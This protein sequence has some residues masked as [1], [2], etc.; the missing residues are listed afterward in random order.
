MGGRVASPTLVGR[1]EE[2][3]LLEAARGRAADAEPA[4]VLVGGEAGVGKTRLVTEL[5]SRCAADGTSVLAGG[6]V[7]VGGDGLP[8]AP[9]TEALRP[10]P[11]EFGADAVRELAGPS[12]RELARLLPALGEPEVGPAGQVAQARLFELVLGL[13]ARLSQQTPVT[14]VVEDLHWADQSTRDLLAFLVRNLRRERVL[15]VATYRS[16]EP[17][18]DRLGPW[19]AELDRGGPVRRLELAR[20]DRAETVAQLAGILGAVPATD[21]VDELYGRS[22]GNPFFTEELLA[23]VRARSGALPPTLRDLL[24]GRVQLLPDHAQ[25]VLAVAAVAGRQVPH[26][27]LATVA[28]LDDRELAE[29]LRSVIA[30]RLLATRPGEDGYQFRHALL[31]EVVDADLLPGERA[32]LHADYA[33]ALS[34]QPELADAA[35]SVAAAELAVHWDAAGEP[36]QALPARIEAGLAAERAHAVAEAARHFERALVL[37]DRVPD[38]GRLTGLDRVDL[39]AHTADAIAF[40]GAA[41]AATELLEDALGRVDPAAEPV[42]A[43]VL[44]ARL[45]DHRRVAGDEAGALAAFEQAERLL[46]GTPPSAE[47]ARV[48]AAHA[49]A[50]GLGVRPEEALGRSEEA[51]ACA[52]AVGARLE[53]AIALRVLAVHLAPLGQPDR[54]ITLALQ[55]RAIAED[56]DDVETVIGTYLA[57]TFTL[58]L[59]GRQRDVLEEARKGYQRARE[60]GLERATGSFVANNLANCLLDTGRWTECERLTRE[61]LAGDRWG[62]FNLHNALG[63]LLSRRGEFAAAR[64]QLNLARR[65][66]PPFFSDW[67]WLGLAELAL[68]EGRHDEAGAAVAEGLRWCTERDPEGILPDVSSPWYSLALRLEAERAE[69]A[70]ARHAPGE[71][72]EARRRA[73]PVL[74]ALDRLASART[75]QAG[76]LPVAAHVQA[77]QAERFRLEGRSDPGRWRAAAAAWERLEHPYDAAYA[78][79]RQAEALLAERGSRLEAEQVLRGAHGTAVTLGAAPLRRGSSC[80]PSAAASICRNRPMRPRR[81]TRHPPLPHHSA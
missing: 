74:A 6:C 70:A 68:W 3:S 42:R 12:W 55:A 18:T 14:L 8:F 45:G 48:L 43:A 36:T 80:S 13:L 22:E 9:I 51:I 4:V 52:R 28:D 69:Q 25:Q 2:L 35:P 71:V 31:R 60:F 72:A 79:F 46:A 17:R 41:Q 66:S 50:L 53:E 77:A 58:K 10:L 33:R 16:D 67:A 39:L 40:V 1:V 27:L 73:I 11:E 62:A 54:A 64:E 21:L 57:V 61:L 38:R 34:N 76:Y 81:P 5:T 19:L 44:L 75:P 32:R 47:R 29:A 20:L 65:L 37:W 49:Y 56:L 7:P 26:R 15:L 24:R 78:R 59:V 30:H 23:A 63:R